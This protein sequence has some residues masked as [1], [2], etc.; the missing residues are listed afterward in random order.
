MHRQSLDGREIQ[1][2]EDCEERELNKMKEQ[3]GIPTNSGGGDHR[4]GP[5]RFRF[6]FFENNFI[7]SLN[8]I[9]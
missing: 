9:G 1:C 4:G 5:P 8:V 2:F 6:E 7:T 3:K